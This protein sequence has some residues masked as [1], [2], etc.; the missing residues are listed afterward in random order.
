MDQIIKADRELFMILSEELQHENVRLS[1]T[2]SPVEEGVKRLRTDPRVTV[3][4]LPLPVG[5]KTS[6]SSAE[7]PA[8]SKA[9]LPQPVGQGL[10]RQKAKAYKPSAKAKSMC[11]AE[12]KDFKQVDDE[13]RA[14]C[15]GYNMKSG[16]KEQV[17]NGRCKK[18][19]HVCVRCHRANHS[20][21]TCRANTG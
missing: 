16:C 8:S 19:R 17:S 13:G 15:W 5:H 11:P 2:P 12:L 9:P 14:I 7:A 4:L 20:L 3:H 6:S 1:D 10:K 21:L 18:G